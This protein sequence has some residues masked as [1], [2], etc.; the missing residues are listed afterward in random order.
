[1]TSLFCWRQHFL[2]VTSALFS[3]KYV[4]HWKSHNFLT[5]Y[6][7]EVVDLSFCCYKMA[8]F[9]KSCLVAPSSNNFADVSTFSAPFEPK[10]RKLRHVTSRDVTSPDFH[11]TLRKCFFPWYLTPVQIWSQLDNF[12]EVM[13]IN[14]FFGFY[15]EYIGKVLFYLQRPTFDQA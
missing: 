5:I 15:M 9:K 7:R 13:T 2:L 1:M 12:Y 11:Q 10:I 3:W 14:I 6:R 8:L 4:F